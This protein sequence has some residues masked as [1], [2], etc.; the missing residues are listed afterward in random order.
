MPHPAAKR[1]YQRALYWPKQGKVH[2]E[3]TLAAPQEL[4]VRWEWTRRE[5]RAADSSTIALD[6]QVFANQELTPGDHL[7]LAPLMTT[8]ALAQWH[9]A[10]VAAG[11]DVVEVVTA[12]KTPDLRNRSNGYTAS[13]QR[14]RD[15]VP[16]GWGILRIPD[17]KLWLH[18]DRGLYEASV[19]TNA[20]TADGGIRVGAEP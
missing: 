9:G 5:I 17:L 10:G 3:P 1:R 18:A 13:C 6:A 14:S 11:W 12:G 16:G 4:R 8:T 20:A 19:G 7:W 15:W 2:G